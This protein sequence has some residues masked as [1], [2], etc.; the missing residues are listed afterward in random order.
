MTFRD[1]APE[2]HPDG[3][4]R[5]VTIKDLVGTSTIDFAALPSAQVSSNQ[6][7]NSLHEGDILMP[8]RGDYYP[9][10]LCP[11]LCL[12]T[13]PSGQINVITP[14]QSEVDSGYLA[15]YLNCAEAQNYIKSGTSGTGIQSLSKAK[16]LSLR[17]P[18]PTFKAQR[19]IASLLA[20]HLER[21]SLIEELVKL[22]QLQ[23]NAIGREL[24]GR[25]YDDNY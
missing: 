20:L 14:D 11:H 15:W 8:A 24:L 13:F 2:Y 23:L 18:I 12:P 21:T 10:R 22:D 6:F 5:I 3:S 16:L 17:V 19:A 1:K 25:D 4:A 9:A 7:S